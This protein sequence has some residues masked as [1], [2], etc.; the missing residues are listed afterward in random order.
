MIQDEE[1]L[2]ERVANGDRKAF[3]ILY[4]RH[5]N[6]LYRYVYLF[7]KSK[8]ISEEIIQDVFIKIWEH[9]VTLRKVTYFKSYLFRSAK[10][11]L[12]DEIRRNRTKAKIFL[13]LGQQTEESHEQS[14][15]NIICTQYYQIAQDAINLL[16]KKRKEIVELRTKDDLSLDEIAEKLSISKFVV[17]K[18]LY[19]GM[20]FIRKHFKKYMEF[21]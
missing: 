11:Q 5:L 10:N 4:L 2:I 14:D 7:T 21:H 8:E 13:T 16:P 19:A 12:L 9:R 3:T 17:K 1:E 15:S 18:Q 6:D 20:H